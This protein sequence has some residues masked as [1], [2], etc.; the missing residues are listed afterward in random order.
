MARMLS[1]RYIWWVYHWVL[2]MFLRV[3]NVMTLVASV[4]MLAL[5]SVEVIYSRDI[6]P[7]SSMFDLV[8]LIVCLIFCLDFFVLMAHSSHRWRFL[9]RNMLVL[10]L[11]I[12]YHALAPLFD[13]DF[14]H[15][16]QMVMSGIVVLRAIL[17]LYITLRWLIERRITR[18]LWAYI[19]TV[20]VATYFAALLFYEFEAPI[21][22]SLH[23]FGDAVWWAWM[24]LTTV[25]A[26]IFP[27]TI[28][29]KIIA[30]LLPILGMAMFP[31]FTIYV[32][33]L[34]QSRGGG[35]SVM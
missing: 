24:N 7:F 29:G 33:S 27:V 23:S 25:G 19:S 3:V 35:G 20:A 30:V 1:A 10:I 18:L 13:I 2:A 4:V 26:A 32:T 31:V 12:P 22:P 28:I 11:S 9:L 15:S 21:N 14:G 34:Y 17:A 16:A 5:L 8:T 6:A